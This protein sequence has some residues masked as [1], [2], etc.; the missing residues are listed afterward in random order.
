MMLGFR[1]GIQSQ[2]LDNNRG[3][4][5]PNNT[6]A[7]SIVSAKMENLGH[8]VRGELAP[9][10]RRLHGHTPSTTLKFM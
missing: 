9:L 2:F 4:F 1:A 8:P 6:V 3:P 7:R 5:P 10:A